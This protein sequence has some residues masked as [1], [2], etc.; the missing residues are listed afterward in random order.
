VTVFPGTS[1]QNFAGTG[2]LLA[3]LLSQKPCQQNLRCANK[4]SDA[5]AKSLTLMIFFDLPRKKKRK[6]KWV[7]K[8][9]LVECPRKSKFV[10]ELVNL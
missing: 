3:R 4:F 5:P 9:I 10:S 8:A 1:Q 2:L 7:S 6:N